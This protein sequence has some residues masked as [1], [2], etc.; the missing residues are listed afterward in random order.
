MNPNK[1]F[2][3][4]IPIVLAMLAGNRRADVQR[5]LEDFQDATRTSG[6][7]MAKLYQH[8]LTVL[9]RGVHKRIL[10]VQ[11]VLA[12]LAGVVVFAATGYCG[13]A[14]LPWWV[15]LMP[16]AALTWLLP[17]AWRVH[18]DRFIKPFPA[19]LVRG[20]SRNRKRFDKFTSNE[21]TLEYAAIGLTDRQAGKVQP[22]TQAQE[23]AETQNS[24]LTPEQKAEEIE[25]R[26][27]LY[28]R[29]P[30]APRLS[31]AALG[32]A[33]QA[34]GVTAHMENV[35][36]LTHIKALVFETLPT[37]LLIFAMA[38]AVGTYSYSMRGVNLVFALLLGLIAFAA[39]VVF[40]V[41]WVLAVHGPLTGMRKATVGVAQPITAVYHMIL[42]AAPDITDVN[43]RERFGEL[44]GQF[45]VDAEAFVTT[46]EQ[47]PL[48]GLTLLFVFGLLLPH[49]ATALA[50]LVIACTFGA[51]Q[52]NLVHEGIDITVKRRTAATRFDWLVTVGVLLEL[53]VLGIA[54][55]ARQWFGDTI[56]TILV[57]V[58]DF[59]HI[60]SRESYVAA[61]GSTFWDAAG[62]KTWSVIRFLFVV[63]LAWFI[64]S[65]AMHTKSVWLKRILGFA[66]AIGVI[67]LINNVFD[68]PNIDAARIG[69]RA[70]FA[71]PVPPPPPS[72]I[73]VDPKGADKAPVVV[74]TTPPPPAPVPEV[75][76]P[77]APVLPPSPRAHRRSTH[78]T[79]VYTS[80]VER[81]CTPL[82]DAVPC[83]SINE[84]ARE[85]IRA[86]C[87]CQ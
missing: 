84:R 14:S 16:F 58:N 17:G 80:N 47:R 52:G 44:T 56:T 23:D 29:T 9:T 11:A 40:R 76:Y 68:V 67:F 21:K 82:A 66:T 74:Q 83:S 19:H 38:I 71:C 28:L 34:V 24:T 73:A 30:F 5:I 41:G 54:L 13:P 57:L 85:D 1:F 72:M 69:R 22:F 60:G 45:M 46:W 64:G 75:V 10:V 48:N 55:F 86:S 70:S 25:R 35:S 18:R 61:V 65:W 81:D 39:L 49:W 36:P 20:R 12:V 63:I 77:P 32:Q 6:D 42:R 4:L 53:A 78:G 7:M 62:Y 15:Y 51:S 8:D 79:T 37:A 43:V 2:D 87:G 27:A 3:W 59:I 50:A 26:N 31:R 33:L